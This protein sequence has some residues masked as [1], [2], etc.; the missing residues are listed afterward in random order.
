MKLVKRLIIAG[1]VLVVLLVVGA[2]A[3][4]YYINDL[5]KLGVEKGGT[6]AL[7]TKT[8]L[9]SADI[10]VFGGHGALNGLAVANPQGFKAPDFLSLGKGELAVSLS[11]LRQDVVEIPKLE[12]ST[13]RVSLERKDGKTNYK[14]ILDN[15][16]KLPSG[17]PNKGGSDTPGKKF[18]V[19]DLRIDDVK[20]SVDMLDTPV[21]LGAI[22][23]PIE[24]VHLTD[25]GTASKG[26]PMA[27]IAGIIVR[28]VLS[29]AG[30]NGKGIIPTDIL[31]DLQ[32]QLGA[33]GDLSSLGVKLETKVGAELGKAAEKAQQEIE[34]GLKGAADKVQDSL[35]KGAGEALKGILGG[36]KDK[37]K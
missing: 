25:V 33:L 2:F 34:K 14:V 4:I 30:E 19:K 22:V 37:K 13:I 23:V 12:L 1:V 32:G 16:A 6:V 15:L 28:A 29:A 3:A 27:D 11:S 26:L 20:V 7:G 24:Q 8:T 18:I 10:S 17:S 9:S 21:S 36:D 31:G 35:Q 5:V